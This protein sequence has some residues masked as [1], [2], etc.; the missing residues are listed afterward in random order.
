MKKG[1]LLLFIMP[2]FTGCYTTGLNSI[3][4]SGWKEYTSS[5]K[6]NNFSIRFP[7]NYE[8]IKPGSGK[9]PLTYLP[10]TVKSKRIIL[11]KKISN[12]PGTNLKGAAVIVEVL[13]KFNAD[14]LSDE[15]K[16]TG[17]IRING[18]NCNKWSGSDAGAGHYAEFEK[19]IANINRKCYVLSFY[20]TSTSI[21]N[22]PSGTVE[23]F[24]KEKVLNELKSII[25][26][27]KIR[28]VKN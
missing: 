16:S 18:V 24:N 7:E 14:S 12:Y 11:N 27:F 20:I 22:Y 5:N 13:K 23:E 28:T 21:H 3:G 19:Y 9:A 25:K 10:L 17:T 6:K 8:L 1:I 15:M 2:F 26:T 4:N